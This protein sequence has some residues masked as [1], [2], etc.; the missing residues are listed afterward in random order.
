MND[1]DC[2]DNC[3]NGTLIETYRCDAPLTG[4]CQRINN[5]LSQALNEDIEIVEKI[6]LCST[7]LPCQ[8]KFCI[9]KYCKITKFSYIIFSGKWKEIPISY[10]SNNITL[11][12]SSGKCLLELNLDFRNFKELRLWISI[13]ILM[14]SRYFC[15]YYHW[16]KSIGIAYF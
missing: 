5:F 13:I 3:E 14:P 9:T 4:S 7:Q 15:N 11:P 2:F 1:A 10:T 6:G 8:S 16:S 12:T